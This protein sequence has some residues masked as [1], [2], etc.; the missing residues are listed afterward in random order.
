[1]RC[2]SGLSSTTEAPIP[3]GTILRPGEILVLG[4]SS[5]LAVNGGYTP[6]LLYDGTLLQLNDGGE[7]LRLRG[8][9]D[10]LDEVDFSKSS[11]PDPTGNSIFLDPKAYDDQSN[12]DGN[13]WC[14]GSASYGNAGLKGTPGVLN[15]GC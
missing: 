8:D 12:D 4:N 6:D 7:R 2:S 3:G 11:F 1:M 5:D 9:G 15:P 10:V 13:Q 14:K